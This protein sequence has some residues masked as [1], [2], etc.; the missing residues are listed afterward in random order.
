MRDNAPT[1]YRCRMGSLLLAH[2]PSPAQNDKHLNHAHGP[3]GRAVCDTRV[4]ALQPS[5]LTE[6]PSTKYWD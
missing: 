6:A 4:S 3:G 1:P 5:W 2:L